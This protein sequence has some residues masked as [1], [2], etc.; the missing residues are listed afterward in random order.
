MNR[1]LFLMCY[2]LS[3][4]LLQATP[5][6]FHCPCQ[7]APPPKP[8]SHFYQGYYFSCGCGSGISNS[9]EIPPDQ[10]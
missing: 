3:S 6:A 1:T 7:P 4:T 10:G 9:D 5:F 2:L 8:E